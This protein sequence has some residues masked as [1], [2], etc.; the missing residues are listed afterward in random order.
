MYSLRLITHLTGET[1]DA[2]TMEIGRDMASSSCKPLQQLLG[3]ASLLFE[4]MYG[5]CEDIERG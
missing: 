4:W 5:V 3:P 1:H 2:G